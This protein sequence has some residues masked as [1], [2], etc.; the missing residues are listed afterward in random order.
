L[1]IS[2]I[3]P[4][5]NEAEHVEWAVSRA[6]EAGACEVIVADGGSMDDTVAIARRLTCRLVCCQVAGR[7]IQQNAGADVARGDV[8]LFLHADN[9]LEPQAGRQISQLLGDGKWSVG[10]FAQA[11][12]AEGP[13]YRWLE[14]GNAMRARRLGL[15]YG[16]QG[17]FLRRELFQQLGGFA[18]VRLMEDVDLMQRLRRRREPVAVLP[19]PIHVS[20]RRWQQH[21]VVQQTLRNWS[22]LTAFHLGVSPDYLAG[23]YEHGRV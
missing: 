2:F 12:D 13:V 14:R 16:D 5:L 4:T 6:W 17:I 3:I 20:P 15:A 22:L 7:G 18:P 8:V 23:L 19:G 21:G 10:A 11:I 1:R 9:W